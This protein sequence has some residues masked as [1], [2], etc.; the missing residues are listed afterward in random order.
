MSEQDKLDIIQRLRKERRDAEK[1][2]L[3][4]CQ[5]LEYLVEALDAL[6]NTLRPRTMP[7]P[8]THGRVEIPEYVTKYIDVSKLLALTKEQDAAADR[9]EMLREKLSGLGAT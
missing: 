3:F 5:E 8:A 7:A 1:E 4:V 6:A 2:F 9:L